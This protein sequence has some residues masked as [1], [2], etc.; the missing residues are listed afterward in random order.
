M[1]KR[2]ETIDPFWEIFMAHEWETMH[3]S[4]V[5]LEFFES[6]AKSFQVDHHSLVDVGRNLLIFSMKTKN[7]K[8]VKNNIGAA[9]FD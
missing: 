6:I 1:F 3:S 9:P 2:E 8:N 5:K 7:R 4:H